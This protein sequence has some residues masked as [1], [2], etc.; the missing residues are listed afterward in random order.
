MALR[1]SVRLVTAIALGTLLGAILLGVGLL[2]HAKRP[3]SD[4]R[5]SAEEVRATGKCAECHANTTKGVLAHFER[6][7]H[8]SSGVSCFDCHKPQ[9]GQDG[10]DHNGFVIAKHLTSKNC[11]SCH[12]Q[13]YR[14]YES[15]RHA[16]ASW[17]AVHGEGGFTPEQVA[18]AE[19][20]HPGSVKRPP[21]PLTALEGAAATTSGCDACHAVGRPNADG[22]FGQCTECHSRHDSSVSLAREPA[23]CGQCHM[24]P[25]H[26]QLEIY[27]ESKHGVLFSAHKADYNLNAAP[28]ALTVKDMPVPTCATCHMSGLEGAGVTH[29]VSSRLSLYLFAPISDKR[30]GGDEKRA[31]M[32]MLCFNCHAPSRVL[33][34]YAAADHVVEDVNAK[35]KEAMAIHAR[36]AAKKPSPAFSREIDFLAFDLWHYYGRTAKHGAFMGG[37]DFVQWH[38]SYEILRVLNR[39][40]EL[41]GATP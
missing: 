35:V 23:T 25:D 7:R 19:K 5:P 11:A 15:S 22:S 10:M 39:L 17:G 26:S 16:G 8:V 4:Q 12:P 2:L 31:N 18:S 37:P 36:L 34:V 21:H 14:Q 33:G 40:K 13:E 38:G 3:E 9:T 32:Q 41:E 24:G 6:S 28:K 20:A 30:P 27:E 1:E 29:D